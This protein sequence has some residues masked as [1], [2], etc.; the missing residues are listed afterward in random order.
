M[1]KRPVTVTVI[2]TYA[3]GSTSSVVSNVS[4]FTDF[5]PVPRAANRVVHHTNPPPAPRQVQ[6]TEAPAPDNN[7]TA[8]YP[9]GFVMPS[10]N[11]GQSGFKRRITIPQEVDEF[12][13]TPAQ[14]NDVDLNLATQNNNN[15]ATMANTSPTKSCGC[16]LPA[17]RFQ[18]NKPGPHQ[19]QYFWKCKTNKC[20]YYEWEE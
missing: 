17:V 5:P 10:N 2:T 7:P 9:S 1:S 14:L 8:H 15:E 4:D 20:R 16:N 12:G 19:G 3:D 11:L 6:F 13:Y 18:S